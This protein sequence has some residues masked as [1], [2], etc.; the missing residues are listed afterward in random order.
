VTDQTHSAYG[1]WLAYMMDIKRV[2]TA[3]LAARAGV[4]EDDINAIIH[5]RLAP[6]EAREHVFK[7][8]EIMLTSPPRERMERVM[9]ALDVHSDLRNWR[10]ACDG[11]C[12][13]WNVVTEIATDPA[14]DAVMRGT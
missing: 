3:K 14:V 8:G 11:G 7:L 6:E 10:E 1:P 4:S 2:D 5:G 9:K 12:C 13:A